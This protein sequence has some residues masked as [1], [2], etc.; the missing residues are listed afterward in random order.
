M[1]NK[2]N[3]KVEE[4]GVTLIALVVTMIVLLILA[5]ITIS[6]YLND[7]GIII[8][9]QEAAEGYREAEEQDGADFNEFREQVKEKT[10]GEMIVNVVKRYVLMD[11]GNLYMIGNNFKTGNKLTANQV[12][13]DLTLI[14]TN[15]AEIYN[16]EYDYESYHI[17]YI[18]NDNKLYLRTDRA[19]MSSILLTDSAKAWHANDIS[20]RNT[21]NAEDDHN[22]YRKLTYTDTNND[23]YVYDLSQNRTIKVA[24]NVKSFDNIKYYSSYDNQNNLSYYLTNSNEVYSYYVEKGTATTNKVTSNASQIKQNIES[25]T[26]PYDVNHKYTNYRDKDAYSTKSYLPYVLN[27]FKNNDKWYYNTTFDSTYSPVV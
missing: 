5:G 26:M 8:R 18:T 23:F 14:D 10:K 2:R 13:L 7:K 21:E 15:V 25:T 4:K 12:N 20:T 22:D 19:S 17:A 11:N 16:T 6:A 24:E 3:I 1:K 9:A 27:F